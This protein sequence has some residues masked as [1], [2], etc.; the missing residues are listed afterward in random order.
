MDE[1]KEFIDY[2]KSGGYTKR[3]IEEMDDEEI[4]ELYEEYLLNKS[5]SDSQD[6][7]YNDDY[8]ELSDEESE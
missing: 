4:D 6:E 2:L 7:E 8:R 5:G 1:S 3:D